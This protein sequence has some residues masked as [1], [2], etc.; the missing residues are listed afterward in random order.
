MASCSSRV[1]TT[2]SIATCRRSGDFGT[3]A[4][5]VGNS[6]AANAS[7][8]ET[9]AGVFG[10]PTTGIIAT[11]SVTGIVGQGSNRSSMIVG[12]SDTTAGQK[13]GSVT[14]GFTSQAVSGSGLS[15]TAL[16]A[17]NVGVT[18]FAYTGQ[19]LWI[20]PGSGSWG[21][22]VNAFGNWDLAGGVPGLDGALSI[23]DTATFGDAISAPATV[24]LDGANPSLSAVTFDQ[25]S[26][27]YTL[28]QGSGGTLILKGSGGP[29]TVTVANGSH[30]I[31][32]PLS[33]ATNAT[34]TVANASDTLTVAGPVAGSDY[35]I[36]KDGAG[37]L[38]LTGTSSYTGRTDVTLGTL[39]V[40]GRIAS[41]VKV[42]SR[43]ILAGTGAT[44]A[45]TLENGGTLAPGDSTVNN[46]IGIITAT[47]HSA[48][49]T[50]AVYEWQLGQV[51]P[52]L[53]LQPVGANPAANYDQ[54]N[55]ASGTLAV[56]AGF[57]FKLASG[58]TTPTG[59]DPSKDYEWI[60]AKTGGTITNAA[61]GT[62]NPGI[63][64]LDA[65]GVKWGDPANFYFT[66]G[67][68]NNSEL[69]LNYRG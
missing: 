34:V 9:L 66:L 44:G 43:G 57:E 36:T 26:Q 25:A 30:T 12:I 64:A 1:P 31:S 39:K 37:T 48:W 65:S 55:L 59:W 27:A 52:L 22:N 15:D 47:G 50:G 67:G 28:A 51:E 61:G 19:S 54:F 38:T 13:T 40:N 62:L 32:T 35:G 69:V 68:A 42:D 24:R 49:E 17:Q 11:G 41:A 29:A 58:D 23:N 4:L 2:T 16:A 63:I 53:V 20:N 45:V 5:T 10:T 8:T 18:G 6:A 46:G 3:Q 56:S 33:L 14:V 60:V 7:F 21:N